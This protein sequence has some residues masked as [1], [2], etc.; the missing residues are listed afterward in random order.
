M[1]RRFELLALQS[2]KWGIRCTAACAALLGATAAFADPLA[3]PGYVGPLQPAGDPLSFDGGVLGHVYMSGQLS[4][5]GLVQ[6]HSTDGSRGRGDLSN[7]QFELQT[8]DGPLQFY[9]QAGA[10]SLPALGSAYIRARKATDDL[11]GVLPVAYA[12]VVL[13]SQLSVMA[14]ALP[15]LVGAESTFTFQNMNIQRGLLWNQEPAIS[16]GVQV[17]YSADVVNAAVSINDGFY[18]GKYNW[19]SG[20]LSYAFDT[21]NTVTL[22]GAGALSRSHESSAATP[23]VQNNGSIFNLIYSHTQGALTLT[24]YLQYSEVKRDESLGLDRSAKAYGAALLAKVGFDS[25]WSLATRAEYLKSS[26]GSC[27]AMPDCQSTSLL[28]GPGSSAWSVTITPTWQ[29]GRLFA[30]GELGY[31]RT[32]KPAAGASFGSD[33]TQRGQLRALVEAGFLF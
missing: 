24:P 4:A 26:G 27:G 6:S 18:S 32:V 20:S 14:G 1:S 17:N 31:V 7:A 33:G 28:F 29:S 30:R 15:T 19:V 9:A 16:R 2:A 21:S 8:I 13:N 11:Y 5:L 3:S 12:K 10:Y 25:E 22:V 23:L